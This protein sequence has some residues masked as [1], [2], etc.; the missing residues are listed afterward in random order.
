MS[1]ATTDEN[2]IVSSSNISEEDRKA[3]YDA[4]FG[5]DGDD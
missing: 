4:L 3:T 5:D 1:T 2:G